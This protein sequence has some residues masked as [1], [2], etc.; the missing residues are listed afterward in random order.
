MAS[1]ERAFPQ[2][3]YRS[4]PGWCEIS[5][6][7]KC[8][9]AELTERDLLLAL[10]FAVVQG[11]DGFAAH[12]AQAGQH[13]FNNELCAQVEHS[14]RRR[15]GWRGQVGLAIHRARGIVRRLGA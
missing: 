8:E 6:L 5:Y 1:A 15:A 12:L 3:F 9:S 2:F 14:I 4:A 11:Q 7:N 10:V 13:R